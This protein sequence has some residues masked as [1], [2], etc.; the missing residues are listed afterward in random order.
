LIPHSLFLR[1]VAVAEGHKTDSTRRRELQA[2]MNDL[3]AVQRQMTQYV[4]DVPLLISSLAHHNPALVCVRFHVRIRLLV[5]LLQETSSRGPDGGT[6]AGHLAVIF[7][8]LIAPNMDLP[9]YF[10]QLACNTLLLIN[11]DD[12]EDDAGDNQPASEGKSENS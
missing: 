5:S 4:V 7:A 6:P 10:P 2:L 1:Y 12:D 8:P 3:P 11:T 9:S